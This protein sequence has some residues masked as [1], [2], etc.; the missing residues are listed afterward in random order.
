MILV[1]AAELAM[2]PVL[3]SVGCAETMDVVELAT[4]VT[5]AAGRSFTD[6]RKELYALF[7][8]AFH[9]G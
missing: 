3:S 9:R 7:R 6:V 8:A 5:P 1:G 2:C 4:V